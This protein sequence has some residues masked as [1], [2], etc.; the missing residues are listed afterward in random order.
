MNMTK[1]FKVAIF[2]SLKIIPQLIDYS[3]ASIKI[4]F[5]KNNKFAMKFLS[6]KHSKQIIMQ[7]IK[8]EK[9]I[10][11]SSYLSHTVRYSDDILIEYI[12]IFFNSLIKN[13]SPNYLFYEISL[14]QMIGNANKS[15]T[16]LLL[17]QY[18]IN[19]KKLRYIDKKNMITSIRNKDFYPKNASLILSKLNNY[20]KT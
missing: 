12:P 6:L 7:I 13:H 17:E 9:F 15:S 8:K 14:D 4:L 11:V 1:F 18:L 19:D 5:L 16:L 10:Y 3:P 2:Y 20:K